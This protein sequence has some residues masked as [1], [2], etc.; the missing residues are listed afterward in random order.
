MQPGAEKPADCR[1]FLLT[2]DV[3]C[4]VTPHIWHQKNLRAKALI[5]LICVNIIGLT[6]T[7]KYCSLFPIQPL[8]L[9]SWPSLTKQCKLL[10]GT[11]WNI[12]PNLAVLLM[13]LLHTITSGWVDPNHHYS[14]QTKPHEFA[15]QK[16]KSFIIKEALYIVYMSPAYFICWRL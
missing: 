14:G 1:K 12:F 4:Q 5:W 8:F 9:P 10:T 16:V 11:F 7:S 6:Q 15:E 3:R 2:P 13:H